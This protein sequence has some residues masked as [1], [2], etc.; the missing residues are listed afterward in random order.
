MRERTNSIHFSDS[1]ETRA[2][3]SIPQRMKVDQALMTRISLVS[4]MPSLL[5]YFLRKVTVTLWKIPKFYHIRYYIREQ[6]N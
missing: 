3:V 5:R 1:E 2:A 6:D 4:R